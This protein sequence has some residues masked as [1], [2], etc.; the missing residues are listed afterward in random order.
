MVDIIE[1]SGGDIVKFIGDAILI[2][3]ELKGT[4]EE[5]VVSACLGCFKLLERLGD[6]Q[7]S[8]PGEEEKEK[9]D[10]SMH[11]G[12]AVGESHDVHVG[13]EER[14]EYFLGGKTVKKAGLLVNVAQKKEIAI[15]GECL[16]FLQVFQE[17]T[18][19]ELEVEGTVGGIIIRKLEIPTD[20]KTGSGITYNFSAR[21]VPEPP[22]PKK[23]YQRYINECVVHRILSLGTTDFE[24]MQMINE[25]RKLTVMFIKIEIPQKHSL[26]I[27]STMQSTMEVVQG[28]LKV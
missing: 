25:L 17:A 12:L 18:Q 9:F 1:K 7:V 23:V 24:R 13:T 21:N 26:Q 4:K 5:T 11:I 3:W 16:H 10:L 28:V 2:A 27:L 14:M 19:I 8:I 22:T 15:S 20:L 6:H